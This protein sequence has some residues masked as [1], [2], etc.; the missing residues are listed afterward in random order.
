MV[1]SVIGNSCFLHSPL[2]QFL[3]S[4]SSPL[5]FSDTRNAL[6]R[7]KKRAAM[8][9]LLQENSKQSDICAR[10]AILF[11]G[12]GLVPF[13]GTRADAVDGYVVGWNRRGRARNGRSIENTES[14]SQE[15]T[16]SMLIQENTELRTQESTKSRTE[17]SAELGTQESAE[18]KTQDRIPN[19][20]QTIKENASPAPHPTFS[21]INSIGV[22]SS[23]VLAALYSSTTKEKATSDATIESVKNKL[24]EK[25]A[26]ITNMEKEFE[27]NMLKNEEA[28]KQDFVKTNEMQQSLI[29]RL[30][31]ANGTITNLGKQVQN[32][33][34]LNQALITQVENLERNLSKSQDE[35][36]ELQIPMQE[37]LDSVAA[38]QEKIRVLS[39]E[40]TV[41]EDDLQNFDYKVVEK[42]RECDEL[43]SVY[44]KSRDQLKGLDSEIQEL[45]G[46]VSKSE[47]E[48]EMKNLTL[49]NLNKELTS[50]ITERDESSK[51]LDGILKEF[52]EFK[53]SAEKKMAVDEERLGEREKQ[54]HQ[55]QEQL[56]IALDEVNKDGVLIANLTRE[57]ENLREKLDVELR[58]AKILE[59]EL[60]ITQE[61]LQKS[62]NEASDLS[63]QLQKSRSLCS[64]LEAE[65][66]KVKSEFTKASESLQC[67]IDEL[68]EG[69]ESLAGELLSVKELLGE[70]NE[71]LEIMSRE[72]AAAVQKCD[73]SEKELID[74]HRKAE[75]AADALT[76]ERKIVSSL[77]NELLV[78]ET[79]IS[80]NKEAQKILEADLAATS[81]SFG[82]KTQNE[83]TLLRNLE[84]ANSTISSFEDEKNALHK[85]LDEQKQ[86]N[87]EARK[88]LEYATNVV[89]ELGKELESLEKRGKKLQHELAFAKGEILQ[90]RSQVNASKTKENNQNQQNLEARG[91]PN[92]KV[93]RRRKETDN[94]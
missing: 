90:L 79:E 65:V 17:E 6:C 66:S 78:F 20:E 38:L 37:K 46:T 19:T 30:N 54:L 3:A 26:A 2:C 93:Y 39:S 87:Q 13:L 9:F 11:M 12:F 64:E 48:L 41:K 25:E 74:A 16:E 76:E 32:E 34:R 83:S 61:T 92:K 85:S 62:R 47:M 44:Q 50:L 22:L 73:S 60:K 51:K 58:T 52:D 21:V 40:I 81:R 63:K 24:K 57:N 94:S 7:R 56:N 43:R 31:S 33:R 75:A 4:D 72:L 49:K 71:K 15:N 67:E 8:A 53:F 14:R 69:K 84:S 77:N 91:K 36:R 23:G 82:E 59:Q 70:M 68:K 89:M 1:G 86:M 27:S 88:N 80:R 35:K 28:R 55:V 5:P 45:K 10:R 42:E 18:L 29:N